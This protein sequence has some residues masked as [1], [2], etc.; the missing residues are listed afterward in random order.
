[1]AAGIISCYCK[2]SAPVFA[3]INS[4]EKRLTESKQR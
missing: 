1:M 4:Y 3:S 2:E